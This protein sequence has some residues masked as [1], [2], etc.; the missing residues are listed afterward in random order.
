MLQDISG[1]RCTAVSVHQWPYEGRIA[2]KWAPWL[3]RLAKKKR[4][5]KE[6]IPQEVRTFMQ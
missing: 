5:A 2:D 6:T 4:I 1:K 3:A